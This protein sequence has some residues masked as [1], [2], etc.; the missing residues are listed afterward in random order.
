MDFMIRTRNT[1][2]KKDR[3]H[4]KIILILTIIF[5]LLIAFIL[6]S[7]TIRPS[8]RISED[9]G[10][11][12]CPDGNTAALSEMQPSPQE[13]MTAAG[14]ETTAPSE[15]PSRITLGKET[16]IPLEYE[17]SDLK[18]TCVAEQVPDAFSSN[19]S[20]LVWIPD[21]EG[22]KDVIVMMH[23]DKNPLESTGY[24]T[25]WIKHTYWETGLSWEIGDALAAICEKHPFILI[26]PNYTCWAD[27]EIPRT[28]AGTDFLI[29]EI[30]IKFLK[31]VC[32]KFD[33]Y[34]EPTE[35]SIVKNR[36]HFYFGGGSMGANWAA[37][38]IVAGLSPFYGSFIIASD[39]TQYQMPLDKLVDSLHKIGLVT[40]VW[41]INGS[42]EGQHTIKTWNAIKKEDFDFVAARHISVLEGNHRYST[43]IAGLDK[44]LAETA[45][46][47]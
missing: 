29:P 1:I 47:D 9:T 27:T 35:E 37:Q 34:A 7:Q 11:N 23:S 24:P 45:P 4:K 2:M 14:T 44:I 10:E 42:L 30:H 21:I 46:S 17:V 20:Y 25:D 33:T 32:S 16:E 3:S 43:W 31:D 41:C 18:W 6:Y 36:S 26:S 40:N 15:P 28:R 8:Q 38:G 39:S 19:Q 12:E 22:P 5:V 13:N